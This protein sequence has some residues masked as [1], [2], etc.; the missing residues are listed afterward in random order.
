MSVNLIPA[1]QAQEQFARDVMAAMAR[2][3]KLRPAPP[4]GKK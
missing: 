3:L 4:K 1:K 2:S